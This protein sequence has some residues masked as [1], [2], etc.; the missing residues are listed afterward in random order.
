[1]KITKN[2]HNGAEIFT[3][4][5]SAGMEISLGSL[6]AGI[7]GIKVP[8][9]SGGLREVIKPSGSGYG[10]EYNGLT[11]G[12]TAGR[13]ADAEF[14]IDGRTAK[15]DKNNFNTDNL[16]GGF[17]GLNKKV[18]N[19][20]TISKSEFTD[21][22]FGCVSCDGEG[23][24]F[25][26][27]R[28]SII[29]RIYERRNRLTIIFEAVPD[30][31]TLINL[32]NHAYFNLS[33][34]TSE[35]I[36][37]HILYLGASYVGKPDERLIVR[38]TEKVSPKFDFRIPRKIGDYISDS[39]VAGITGGYDH[40]YFLDDRGGTAGWLYSEKSG[41]KLEVK[42]SYPCVVLYSDNED[43]NKSVCLECQYHPNGIHINPSDC[44]ICTPEKPYSEFTEFEFKIV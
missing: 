8:D 18:F 21:V 42:T 10:G 44:G 41:I 22:K 26:N 34:D 14:E 11:V 25:G 2:T 40:P 35:D 9:R 33:G 28:F 19:A 5:N 1:M 24:Y 12:R 20:E 27:V 4:I 43:G 23:G 29:Y 32:T 7:A 13:I 36:K 30:C 37:N 15:L 39:E 6:G 3:L 31:K 17:S 38:K 16:H